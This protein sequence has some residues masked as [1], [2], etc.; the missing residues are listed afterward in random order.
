MNLNKE[1]DNP[2]SFGI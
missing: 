2:T 1:Q